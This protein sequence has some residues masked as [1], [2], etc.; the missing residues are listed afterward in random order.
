MK[1]LKQTDKQHGNNTETT[2]KSKLLY[3]NL[4]YQ[5]RGAIFEVYKRLGPYHKESVYGNALN[6]EL[7]KR[8]VTFSRQKRVEIKY[9]NKKVGT[10][11]P[12]FVVDNKIILEIKATKFL[13]KS[14]IQ[15]LYYYLNGTS[16]RLAFLVNFNNP[17]RVKIIRR[18][19]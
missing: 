16:Y 15:Q 13:H 2:Q 6:E 12:D 1:Q 7:K 9:N 14:A 19:K 5:V 17:K 3:P 18:I 4:S 10:Y 11:I 8:K